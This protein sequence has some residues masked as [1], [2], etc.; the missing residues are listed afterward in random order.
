[1]CFPAALPGH[2]G[3]TQEIDILGTARSNCEGTGLPLRSFYRIVKDRI[4]TIEDFY[5]YRELGIPTLDDPRTLRLAEGIS[6][7]ETF[8]QAATQAQKYPALGQFIAELELPD[9][10]S[11]ITITPSGAR[12]GHR[13]I[14]VEPL[15]TQAAIFLSRVK[16]V[17][18]IVP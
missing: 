3:P 9:D 1:M 10:D 16:S 5:S 12:S 15:A 18:S 11:T 4:P 6:V 8:A 14:W 7:Y 2:S 13:T 17:S